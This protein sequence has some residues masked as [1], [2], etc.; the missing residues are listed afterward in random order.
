MRTKIYFHTYPK[1]PRF[2]RTTISRA[3]R[4]LRLEALCMALREHNYRAN[5]FL[6]PK[7]GNSMAERQRR[8]GLPNCLGQL[9]PTGSAADPCLQNS[10]PRRTRSHAR[11]RKRI[12][13]ASLSKFYSTC[14]APTKHACKRMFLSLLACTKESV[15]ILPVHGR[16]AAFDFDVVQTTKYNR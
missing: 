6:C 13:I 16:D 9:D 7:T 4:K 3:T 1:R 5:G 11:K 2:G 12:A 15:A 8:R 14:V 10:S